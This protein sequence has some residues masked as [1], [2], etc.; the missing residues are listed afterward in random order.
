[1]T[2]D[3]S[4][5]EIITRL[6]PLAFLSEASIEKLAESLSIEKVEA[7]KAVFS[8]GDESMQSVYLIDGVV[9][10]I[11]KSEAGEKRVALNAGS[12]D[13]RYPIGDRYPRQVDAIAGT[14]VDI[15]RI[16]NDLMDR[17][18]ADDQLEACKTS[19][20][21]H[22]LT[23]DSA[24]G[25][26]LDKI[27]KRIKALFQKSN[28]VVNKE[29]LV[30]EFKKSVLFEQLPDENI[31]ELFDKMEPVSFKAGSVV[32][33][34]GEEGDFYYLI[35]SGVAEVTRK[36][37]ENSEPVVLAELKEGQ[38]FGEEALVS[39]AKR[40][41]TVSMKTKGVLL[42]LSKGDFVRLL[43]EPLLRW[44]SAMEAQDEIR[45]GAKWLDV[46]SPAEYQIAH[47]PDAISL[48]LHELRTR[49]AELEKDRLYICCCENG[50]LSSSAVF[51]LAQRGIKCAV[52]RGG[53]QRLSL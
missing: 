8:V 13:A 7:G 5:K 46:R 47:L 18:I 17:V 3:K 11:A 29:L 4:L 52:L 22:A 24:S 35:A 53:I 32:I 37:A 36:V 26:F 15:I 25:G 34:Q 10:L 1:M 6:E 30:E 9:N 45:N 40:N 23:A 49:A 28:P 50:R 51:L 14:D 19:V 2:R 12:P 48:P 20:V 21:D 33:R 31:E 43:K 44:V 42:R 27:V 39:N 16:D 38:G 41:A